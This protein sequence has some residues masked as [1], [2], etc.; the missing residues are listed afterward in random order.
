MPPCRSKTICKRKSAGAG[1]AA[2]VDS[3]LEILLLDSRFLLAN[4]IATDMRS[5]VGLEAADTYERLFRILPVLLDPQSTMEQCKKFADVLMPSCDE[6]NGSF[7]EN[8]L[9]I[10]TDARNRAER[11]SLTQR[12]EVKVE[13]GD[14]AS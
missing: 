5:K 6:A 4:P 10:T 7:S 11:F 8:L 3:V 2:R 9:R 13:T 12:I 1:F 14:V